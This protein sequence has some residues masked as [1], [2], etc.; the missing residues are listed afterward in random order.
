MSDIMH[1]INEDMRRQQLREFWE[2]NQLWIIGGIVLAIVATAALT[3]WRGHV[4]ERNQAATSVLMST[5]KTPA[6]E[7]LAALGPAGEASL[8]AK[9]LA[10]L[11]QLAAAHE[12]LKKNDTTAALAAYEALANKR[13]VDGKWRD[14]ARLYA[15]SLKIDGGNTD[16]TL[17]K[18]LADLAG[19]KNPWRFTAME[20]QALLL[21]RQGKMKE[22]AEKL[23]LISGDALAPQDARTRAFTL[24]ELYHAEAQT[25]TAPAK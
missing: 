23:A 10:A 18:E 16:A 11:A 17:E 21:A 4:T 7:K 6:P 5:L 12:Y 2:E 15:V 24:H 25:T 20:M 1:E 14:L 13:G 9:D 19:A 22:A 8:P 3:F